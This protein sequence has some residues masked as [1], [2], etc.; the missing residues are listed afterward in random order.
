MWLLLADPATFTSA[1][2]AYRAALFQICPEIAQAARLAHAF[3]RLVRARQVR[4]L[5]PWIGVADASGLR[6]IRR[7]A[8]GLQQDAAVR[9][10]LE[11]P[12]SQGQTE[13][14]V[15]RLKLLKRQMYGR[16]NFDVLRLRVLHRA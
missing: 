13:G 5:D 3:V 16:A 15:T 11:Q 10:A 1:D 4:E 8:L 9:A 6:E 12:W 7:F 2:T 14:Q